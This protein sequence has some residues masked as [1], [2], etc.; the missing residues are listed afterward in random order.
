MTPNLIDIFC[1]R[2][3]T[4]SIDLDNM[5]LIRIRIG[6]KYMQDRIAK[7][8]STAYIVLATLKL[9]IE[10]YTIACIHQS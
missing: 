4:V 10:F 1:L 3:T 8:A 2:S 5:A 6:R 9:P 7:R